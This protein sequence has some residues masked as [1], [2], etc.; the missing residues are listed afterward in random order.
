MVTHTNKIMLVY[1]P[2]VNFMRSEDRCQINVEA[3]ACN[4]PR[5]CNDL[6]YISAGLKKLGFNNI[7]L[8]DYQVEK[9]SDNGF[10][11]D[12]KTY[13]PDLIFIS[14]TNGSIFYDLNEISKFKRMY[15]GVIIILK[16]AVFFD[17]ENSLFDQIN[18]SDVDYLIGGESEFIAP[19]LI[20]SIF[21][22]KENIKNI[23]G[24]CYKENEQWYQNKITGFNENI[25]ELPFPDRSAMKNNLYINPDTNRPIATISTARGC[26]FDCIYCLSPVISGKKIRKRSCQNVLE[27]IKDC[28]LNY[29][30]DNFFFK[31]DTFTA[32]KDWV[33]DL[34]NLIIQSDLNGK[35]SWVAT[36]RSNTIDEEMIILMKKAGCKL[37]A[38]GFESGSEESL[39]L[40]KKNVTTKQNLT[41]AGLC[42]KYGI[43][44]LGHFLIGLPWE[45]ASHILETK[46]HMFEIDADYVELAIAVPFLHTELFDMVNPDKIIQPDNKDKI[47]GKDSFNN[48][49]CCTKALSERELQNYRKSI[50]KSYYIR[51]SYIIKKLTSKNLNLGIIFNYV[52]YGFRLLKNTI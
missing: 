28:F 21:F 26:P 20:N 27:E 17:I 38:F 50:L 19:E 25:D 45:N 36:S 40:M 44:M 37:I 6:G 16:G 8:K 5:A 4:A 14:T 48:T 30:I 46:K 49:T 22:D 52:K 13:N 10:F 3:S 7:F 1:P 23:E 12:I 15:P 24:I 32:D 41:A 34:C 51:P 33:M 39:K 11:T 31:S 35:I 9:L 43:K 42:K 2:G 47:L 29:N 18:L